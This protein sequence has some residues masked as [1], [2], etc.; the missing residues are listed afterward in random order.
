MAKTQNTIVNNTAITTSEPEK[1]LSIT[2]EEISIPIPT[3]D[4]NRQL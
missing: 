2:K 1:T 3:L 4:T